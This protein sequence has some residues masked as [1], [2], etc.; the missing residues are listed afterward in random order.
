MK[1]TSTFMFGLSALITTV[2]GSQPLV[3]MD[4]CGE[5]NDRYHFCVKVSIR[6]HNICC[7]RVRIN[8]GDMN[9]DDAQNGHTNGQEG[10][11]TTCREHVCFQT[12]KVR[13]DPKHW[14]GKAEQG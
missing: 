14:V 2:H 11:K 5:C 1:L 4:N 8:S 10:C 3:P 9:A 12:P 13:T 6:P 7:P